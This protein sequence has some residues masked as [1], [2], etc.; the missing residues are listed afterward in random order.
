MN[1]QPAGFIQEWAKVIKR[2]R[3]SVPVIIL[4]EAHKPFSF[5][6]SQFMLLGQPV[7]DMV[8]PEQFTHKAIHLFSNR[9]NLEG[10]IQELEQD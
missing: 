10:F 1:S 5:I 2:K 4:L 6:A 3:L 7:L 9:T 8:L